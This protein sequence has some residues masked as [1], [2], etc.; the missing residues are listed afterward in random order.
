MS[1]VTP[2][3]P[4]GADRFGDHRRGHG[5]LSP[6]EE[7]TWGALA[8]VVPGVAFVLSAG[9]LGFV[10]SI[11]IHLVYK[12]RG[13]F[14]RLHT[15]NSLNVQLTFLV[16][17]V[18]ALPLMLILV[19]FAIAAFAYALVLWVHCVGALRAWSGEPYR[20]HFTIPFVR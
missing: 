6:S 10:A 11:V 9:T 13:P 17:M 19:G 8:H 7:R 14:V 12:D 4:I 18:V 5:A 15:A 20:P 1:H 2:H 3:D 16:L